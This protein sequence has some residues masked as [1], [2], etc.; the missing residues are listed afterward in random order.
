MKK[1]LSSYFFWLFV[2]LAL[3]ALYLLA[4]IGGM[5]KDPIFLGI[6]AAL[7]LAALLAQPWALIFLPWDLQPSFLMPFLLTLNTVMA[8]AA[9]RR[10]PW[11][12]RVKER[13]SRRINKK[14]VGVA[15]AVLILTLVGRFFD[16]PAL[17]RPLPDST[18]A[19]LLNTADLKYEK[20]RLYYLSSFLDQSW[21]WRAEIRPEEFERLVAAA[22]MEPI[23]SDRLEA[24]FFEMLAYWWNPRRT[25]TSRAYATPNFSFTDRGSDGW[26][27]VA[28]WDPGTSRVYMWVKDN[29]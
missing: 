17:P 11:F 29:F 1:A 15:F 6:C 21:I 7:G 13:V 18:G 26:H 16:F 12:V 9:L 19:W 14:Y 5:G 10:W 22:A 3:A 2:N 8:H 24:P 28:L 27:A 25:P 23:E 4:V 20:S